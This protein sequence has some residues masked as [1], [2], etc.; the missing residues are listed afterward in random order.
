[1]DFDAKL[2]E[3][4][5]RH[6]SSNKNTMTLHIDRSINTDFE[7]HNYLSELFLK[8]KNSTA[9]TIIIDMSKLTFIAAN[10]FAI[11]GCIIDSLIS[12]N[13]NI[14]LGSGTSS[15]LLTLMCRNDFG[16]FFS[17]KSLPDIN[18]TVIPYKHFDVNEIMEYERYLTIELFN[19]SDMP[20]MSEAVTNHIRDYLL[21]IFKNVKDHTS[22]NNVY[23]CGQF[24]PKKLLL[25]FTIV[26]TGETIPYNVCEYHSKHKLDNPDWAL[27]WALI[28]GN[29]TLDT[30]GPRG[31]GLFL[32]REFVSLNKGYFCIVSD[33]EV[34][35]I[36]SNGNE[37]Y[38]RMNYSF[39][40]TIV[41]IAFNLDDESTY[42]MKEEI[43]PI[44]F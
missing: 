40:G 1:M 13:K 3:F 44:Q 27:K 14:K 2:E 43:I 36:E 17:L 8:S 23:T 29:T 15:E 12:D 37:Y 41:T 10:Q 6:I 4:R 20:N 25:Y 30:D 19:R 28:K 21:E 5:N 16:N 33:D 38:K 31:I 11:L 24:F 7:S 39:P 32:I 22:S 18:K 42:Y 9:T 35:E 26:D 34:Y